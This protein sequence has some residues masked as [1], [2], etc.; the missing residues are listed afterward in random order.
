MGVPTVFLSSAEIYEAMQRG[1]IDAFES[2]TFYV[3]WGRGHHEVAKYHYVSPTRAPM[4]ESTT[5]VNK[6]KWAEIGPD[7]QQIVYSTFENEWQIYISESLALEGEYL[8]KYRD[9]GCIVE[10]LPAAVEA[11]YMEE[12]KEFYAER[13]AEDAEYDKILGSMFAWQKICLDYGIK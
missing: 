13:R 11:A 9:Y 10:P 6:K 1:V 2:N 4:T 7:L 12:A 3:D 8:Q 5:L